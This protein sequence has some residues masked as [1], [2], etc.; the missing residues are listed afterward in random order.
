MWWDRAAHTSLCYC[1]SMCWAGYNAFLLGSRGSAWDV[2]GRVC[3]CGRGA[4]FLSIKVSSG[5]PSAWGEKWTMPAALVLFILP[6]F[7]PRFRPVSGNEW[8]RHTSSTIPMLLCAQSLTAGSW[9]TEVAKGWKDEPGSG[10]TRS[11]SVCL[12][13]M[14]FMCSESLSSSSFFY[15]L[16]TLK[17]GKVTTAEMTADVAVYNERL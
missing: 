14:G 9:W 16:K 5:P 8:G 1:C 15:L 12:R 10:R 3:M 7:P 13:F 6:P 11:V 2:C 17:K 4:A